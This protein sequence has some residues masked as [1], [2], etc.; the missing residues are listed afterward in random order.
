MLLNRS[1]HATT[2]LVLLSVLTACGGDSN[3]TGP[4][5]APRPTPA[6]TPVTTTL[7]QGT[8]TGLPSTW[9]LAVAFA[10]NFA[11]EVEAFVDWTFASNDVDL[12]VARG[13]SNPCRTSDG[14]IDFDIC[15]VLATQAG[16]AKPERMRIQLAAGEYTLYIRNGGAS[17]ESLSY[18][19]LLT[20]TPSITGL[21]GAS[22]GLASI[23]RLSEPLA[24]R[25]RPERD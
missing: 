24:F 20:Y 10:P 8:F 1:F 14:F 19:I 13:G 2:A 15:Q 6:P 5:A 11:G 23:S 22:A 7:R 4:G 16:P 18:R 21:P 9:L 25:A 3:P 12:I 17:E